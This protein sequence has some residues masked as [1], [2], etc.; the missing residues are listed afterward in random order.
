MTI[1]APRIHITGAS[2]CGVTT[3][4]RGLAAR[5]GAAHLDPD[6]FYWDAAAPRYTVKRAITERL[7]LLN[8]AFADAGARGWVLSG[9]LGDW[10]D[11][12]VPLFTQVVFLTAPTDVRVARLRAREME[13]FA[14]EL[15]DP[16]SPRHREIEAF[17]NWAA[18]YDTSD[19]TDGRSRA[20]HEAWLANLA[21]PVLRLDGL[22]P[23]HALVERLFETI[24]R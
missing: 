16:N 6:D 24:K 20:K 7:R 4:G 3:L 22:E 5:I 12:I 8:D 11:P 13:T 2:G 14:A 15:R 17:L 9:S 18:G 23:T 21:C 10:A 19:G 1:Q